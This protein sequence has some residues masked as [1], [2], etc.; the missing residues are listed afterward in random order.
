MNQ[1]GTKNPWDESF[2]G[3]K[4]LGWNILGMSNLGINHHCIF[5][6]VVYILNKRIDQKIIKMFELFHIR[7]FFYRS[8]NLCCLMASKKACVFIIYLILLRCKNSHCIGK[9]FFQEVRVLPSFLN[10]WWVWA[11]VTVKNMERFPDN[12]IIMVIKNNFLNILVIAVSKQR[13][14]GML[15]GKKYFLILHDDMYNK[16]F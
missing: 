10:Y 5:F 15:S 3:Y 8:H 11:E 16:M 7:K 12:F 2:K 1:P 6:S 14:T 9:V 13:A 4:I